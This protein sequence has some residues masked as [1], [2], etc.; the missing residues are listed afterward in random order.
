MDNFHEK[1]NDVLYDKY[2]YLAIV[3]ILLYAYRI[4]IKT[5]I[6]E[7]QIIF[8]DLVG[9]ISIIFAT[10]TPLLNHALAIMLFFDGMIRG[11]EM[12]SG[13]IIWKKK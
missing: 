4:Y 5:L 13:K 1:M 3:I 9:I 11:L 10:F 2:Y 7:K 8:E 12:H 6:K